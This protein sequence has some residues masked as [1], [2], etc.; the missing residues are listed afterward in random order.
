MSPGRILIVDDVNARMALA[1]LLRDE[2][3]DVELAADAVEAL[4]AYAAFAPHVV[5]IDLE[6]LGTHGLEVVHKL[7]ALVDPPAIIV[8]T[9]FGEVST[10]VQ[11]MRAGACDYLTKPLDVQLLLVVLDKLLKQQ[12]LAREMRQVYA[13]LRRVAPSNI[14]GS[15]PSMQRL[16]EIIDQVGP[17]EAT[18]L[19][20]GESGTGKELVA[21]AIHQLSPR[22]SRP[23][24]TLHCTTLVESR[25]DSELFRYG[26]D[27]VTRLARAAGGTLFFDEIGALSSPMQVVLLR[28]LQERELGRAAGTRTLCTVDARVIAA[29]DRNL[30]DETAAGRFHK[31]LYDRLDVVSL[32]LPPLRERRSDIPALVKFF[33]ERYS[34]ENSKTIEGCSAAALE[35]LLSYSWPGNVLELES[36]IE[37]A[38]VLCSGTML[39]P[40]HLPPNIQLAIVPIGIPVIPGATMAAIER[41]AIFET[42]RAAG[43]TS[44]AAEILGISART[45][46]YRVRDYCTA[47][48]ANVVPVR[49]R[50]KG[51]AA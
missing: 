25:L 4:G 46:Q 12:R 29:T 16:L 7:G 22:A 8:M 24:V 48:R 36:A 35:R 14:V 39:G 31:D 32:K 38:V 19:I 18:V 13:Q 6:M 34:E 50:R 17:S 9:E 11:A 47:S 3:F 26:N 21:K 49:K 23:F 1:G 15:T 41:Y 44:R 42:L 27:S 5:V 43:S 10:A 45:I 33:I 20:T 28:F 51:T 30:F 37:R 2:G 40:E